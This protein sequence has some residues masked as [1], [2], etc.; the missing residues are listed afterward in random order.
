[1]VG[2]GNSSVIPIIISVRGHELAARLRT[3]QSSVAALIFV[4][5]QWEVLHFQKLSQ[6]LSWKSAQLLAFQE[7]ILLLCGTIMLLISFAVEAW[8]STCYDGDAAN[9]AEEQGDICTVQG[10]VSAAVCIATLVD[11]S[12]MYFFEESRLFAS[13]P[14]K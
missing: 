12:S 10:W 11:H 4:I 9:A 7:F 2:C 13:C 14:S 6:V 8:Y 1:M 3:A 5:Q